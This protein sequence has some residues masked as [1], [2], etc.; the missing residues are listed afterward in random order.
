MRISIENFKNIK[1]I[2]N[3]DVKPF[4]ILSGINSSGKS[5]FIQFLLLLKQTV[6]ANN[7]AL[8]LDGKFYKVGEYKDIIYKK[9]I[10]NIL[11]F[12]L[13][14]DKDEISEII[15]NADDTVKGILS[16]YDDYIVKVLVKLDLENSVIFVKEFKIDIESNRVLFVN[17]SVGKDRK[18]S[19][20]TNSDFFIKGI[21]NENAGITA[22]DFNSIFPKYCVKSAGKF[23]EERL[24]FNID[25][26]N[27]LVKSSLNISYI[28]PIREEPKEAYTLSK[29]LENI[30][31]RGEFVAQILEEEA[32]KKILFYKIIGNSN[33]LYKKCE[34][35][36]IQAVK[37]WICD[38]FKIAKD[39]RS[40]RIS[41]SYQ[42][43]L[44]DKSQLNVNIKHVGFGVSQLLPI[45]VEGL[46]M[47]DNKTLIIE[48]PEI[49]LH[50]KLQGRLYDFLYGLT[51]QGK[52]VIVETHSSHFITRMRRR[53]A[54]SE[55]NTMSK[56]ISLTFVED[57]I[58]RN[59]NLD[60]Y[61]TMDY[62]PQDF[63][64]QSNTELKAIIEA[65]MKKRQK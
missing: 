38:I 43:I 5:S 60:D 63:I 56:N 7:K 47:A 22:I 46:I 33:K 23:I 53:I 24:A 2:K 37:Y 65:Q 27:A 31:L 13:E 48:Q 44:L 28:K 45:I 21:W 20:S 26:I 58:F 6:E 57:D 29:N 39:I 10:K 59:I 17:C 50:P 15:K 35:T 25:W 19:I 16:S 32:Q 8:L 51:L 9:N 30:G 1:K 18:N 54:E 41:D 62:Y 49:H 3:F 36:L 40:E 61:G 4:T 12:S 42:I 52:K 14:Y 64:E 55:S 34:E 11:T